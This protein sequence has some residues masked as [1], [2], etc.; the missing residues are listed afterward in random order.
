MTNHGPDSEVRSHPQLTYDITVNINGLQDIIYDFEPSVDT[1]SRLQTCHDGSAIRSSTPNVGLA[2]E[3]TA[4]RFLPHRNFIH[5]NFQREWQKVKD[6]VNATSAHSSQ[7]LTTSFST[8][9]T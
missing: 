2:N 8:S 4:V 7:L 5:A 9:S 6:L 3:Q 1:R